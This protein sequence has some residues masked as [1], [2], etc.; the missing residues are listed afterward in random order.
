[1]NTITNNLNMQDRF[2]KIKR[3]LNNTETIG[4]STLLEL[5]NQGEQIKIINKKSSILFD[6]LR[7]TR[8]KL[9]NIISSF[10]INNF[11]FNND[12][13]ANNLDNIEEL[14]TN[15]NNLKKISNNILQNDQLNDG[16]LDDISTKLKTLKFIAIDMNNEIKKQNI[17]INDLNLNMDKLN[18]I[19]NDNNNTM[20]KALK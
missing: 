3:I 16:D 18:N 15:N 20:Y 17:Y 1:M 6:Q 14:K 11:L 4:N 12:I 9:H 19:S 10:Q 13:V 2:E 7:V 8:N 5:N